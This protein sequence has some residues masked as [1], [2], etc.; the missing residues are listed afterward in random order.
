VATRWKLPEKG[1]GRF[2]E[3][4]GQEAKKNNWGQR[5]HELDDASKKNKGGGKEKGYITEKIEN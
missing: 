4:K 5:E 3:K 1:P 2:H